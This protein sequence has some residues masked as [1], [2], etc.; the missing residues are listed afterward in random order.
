MSA[1]LVLGVDVDD[2]LADFQLGFKAV[3]AA[4]L[5]VSIDSLGEPADWDC[6]SWGVRDRDHFEELNHRAVVEQHILRT[7]PPIPGAPAAIRHLH[8]QGV[9][10]RIITHRLRIPNERA[11]TMIDTAMWFESHD[12]PFDDFCFSGDKDQ[13]LADCYIDDAPHNIERFRDAGKH[14]LIFD[15][16]Y[17]RHLSGPRVKHWDEVEPY[18]HKEFPHRFG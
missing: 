1:P 7:L 16:A 2:V 11:L 9:F 12:V 15:Q 4:D 8:K 3:V 18:L 13:I 10:I 5:G 6:L 17:N 14:A